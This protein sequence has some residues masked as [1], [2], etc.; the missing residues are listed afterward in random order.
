MSINEAQEYY[1]DDFEESEEDTRVLRIDPKL[2][3][4]EWIDEKKPWKESP[5]DIINSENQQV[6]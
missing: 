4:A 3:T 1:E 6:P 2:K 5:E